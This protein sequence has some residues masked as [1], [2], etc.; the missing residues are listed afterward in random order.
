MP[1][2][3]LYTIKDLAEKYSLRRHQVIYAFDE[4]RVED[5]GRVGGVKVYAESSLPRIE[6]ALN[7]VGERRT[8]GAVVNGH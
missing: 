5:D 7:R 3:K 1:D 4:F 6:A 2:G 8:S